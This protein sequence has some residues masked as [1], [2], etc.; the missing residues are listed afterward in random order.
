M[1]V[2]GAKVYGRDPKKDGEAKP[3]GE[4]KGKFGMCPIMAILIVA[5]LVYLY[6]LRE[7]KHCYLSIAMFQK[8]KELVAKNAVVRDDED[9]S[10][11]I[12]TDNSA[13]SIEALA[14]EDKAGAPSFSYKFEEPAAL[15]MYG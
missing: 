5:Q 8:A 1:K 11:V 6:T 7:L 12:E 15:P 3:E 2:F 13:E 9:R 10:S 14:S 4:Y